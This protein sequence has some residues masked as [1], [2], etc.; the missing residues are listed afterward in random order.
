MLPCVFI[1][2]F[3]APCCLSSLYRYGKDIHGHQKYLCR[4]CNRQFT[5]EPSIS[6][7]II[8][9]ALFVAETLS[10]GLTMTVITI[11]SAI[12]SSPVIVLNFLLFLQIFLLMIFLFLYVPLLIVFVLLPTLYLLLSF[13][14]SLH[15]FHFTKLNLCYL[16]FFTL[17]FLMFPFV[18]K[19]F[20]FHLFLKLFLITLFK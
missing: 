2:I 8:L 7:K 11:L 18:N 14:I 16:T 4:D 13:F 12:S 15:L 9:N 6:Q 1:Q 19:V 20:T 17:Q 10:Y 5:L 3:L